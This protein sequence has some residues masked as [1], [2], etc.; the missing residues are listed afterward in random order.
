MRS[1]LVCNAEFMSPRYSGG[2]EPA[3]I[4]FLPVF[5]ESVIHDVIRSVPDEF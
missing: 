2:F 4:D 5:I 3:L 1:S